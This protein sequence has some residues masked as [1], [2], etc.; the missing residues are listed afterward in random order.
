[1]PIEEYNTE[2][3]I[4]LKSINR[5][6]E[7]E[8]TS[9]D[10]ISHIEGLKFGDTG[11]EVK[12]FQESLFKLGYLT[13]FRYF[14][15]NFDKRTERVVEAYQSTN[16]ITSTGMIDSHTRGSIGDT[17]RIVEKNILEHMQD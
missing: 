5:S 11:S 1:M 17:I 6:K 4:Y 12:G 15:S 10:V 14:N 16:G 2:Y 7:S 13:D 8:Y 3:T 9:V